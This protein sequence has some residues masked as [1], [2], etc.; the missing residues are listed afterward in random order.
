[1]AVS[2]TAWC[3][4]LIDNDMEG[5]KLA[6]IEEEPLHESLKSHANH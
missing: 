2:E 5:I 3:I 6:C 1:M 4:W